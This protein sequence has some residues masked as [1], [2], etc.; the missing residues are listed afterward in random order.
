MEGIL[1]IFHEMSGARMESVQN[2]SPKGLQ[3][4]QE[5][6]QKGIPDS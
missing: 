3:S 4:L 2:E 5:T 1:K 6:E